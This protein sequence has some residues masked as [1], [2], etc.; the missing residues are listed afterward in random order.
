MRETGKWT[1][2]RNRDRV[3]GAFEKG[4]DVPYLPREEN[5]SVGLCLPPLSMDG[6]SHRCPLLTSSSQGPSVND[7]LGIL[8]QG[9]GRG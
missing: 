6:I 3:R 5:T 2:R 9:E 1:P 7:H 8:E 4:R